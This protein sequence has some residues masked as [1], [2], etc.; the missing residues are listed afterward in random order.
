MF[1]L[2]MMGVLLMNRYTVSRFLDDFEVLESIMTYYFV[3]HTVLLYFTFSNR[4]TVKRF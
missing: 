1:L 3:H 4:N 2:F